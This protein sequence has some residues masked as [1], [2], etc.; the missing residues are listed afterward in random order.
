M[1]E[2]RSIIENV[3]W[4]RI[5]LNLKVR[6]EIGEQNK[7]QDLKFYL[8]NSENRVE[9][10]FDVVDTKQNIF[11]IVINITNTGINR[12]IVNGTY[13]LL[14]TDECYLFSCATSQF[15]SAVLLNKSRCFRYNNNGGAYTVT[16][17]IDEYSSTP[18]FLIQVFNLK[19]ANLANIPPYPNGK[20]DKQISFFNRTVTFVKGFIFRNIGSPKKNKHR[21]LKWIYQ[22]SKTF[23][24][25][26]RRILFLSF[27]QEDLALNM[28]VLYERMLERK[29]DKDFRISFS[30]R[31][32][33]SEKQTIWSKLRTIYLIGCS[34]TIIVDDH[35]PWFDWLV[36]DI[37]KTKLIQIW[38]AGAGFK[39]VGFSRW[40]HFGC[41]GPFNCHRQ[42]S[43]CISDSTKI[44][45]FFAEQ[46]GISEEQVIPTGMPRLDEFLD[47]KHKERVMSEI[48]F[49]YPK[50]K[51]KYV[52]LFAPTYR[53]QNRSTAY[54]PY[55]MLDFK[56]LYSY[57]ESK[58]AAIIF[59]MH[60]W[61]K[62]AVPIPK[63]FED[64]FF[65]FNFYPNINDLFYITDL[66][67]TDYSSGMYEYALMNKPLLAY[68]F[69]KEQYSN[70]RGFHRDYESNVPGRVC[71]NFEELMKALETEDWQFYK[72]SQYINNHF[73][74]HD[75]HNADRVID[76]LVLGKLPDKY[77][78][79]LEL[80]QEKI[81]EQRGKDF[82]FLFD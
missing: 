23:R 21:L 20:F 5:Y 3:S 16:F 26:D 54:Y 70:S 42:Y 32:A 58:N 30:L 59:K 57:C 18:L 55:E 29:L 52:I 60:P 14:I 73:D 49:D 27:Q 76:W 75:N 41:P 9:A 6:C 72:H 13:R 81:M 19:L 61:V 80:H 12:C 25:F 50:I 22:L 35:I 46:F 56:A 66:L 74:L 63:E 15:T 2:F 47:D 78:K 1:K 8:L 68:A 69:D 43:F 31:R 67:I 34:E 28:R 45:H 53:G 48:Y 39:G 24:F 37:N 64:R 17:S 62:E 79:A 11:Q 77:A 44:S 65:N 38:H 36:L 4:D 40:G 51:G 33:T 7:K 71:V 10:A 82:S